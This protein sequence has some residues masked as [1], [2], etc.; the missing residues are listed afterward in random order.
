MHTYVYTNCC[1]HACDSF[2]VAQSPLSLS[3]RFSPS[4][5][6]HAVSE[7][8]EHSTLEGGGLSTRLS[9]AP[10]PGLLEET[11]S[12][13]N[14]PTNQPASQP[15][16]HSSMRAELSSISPRH[17]V[18]ATVA[19]LSLMWFARHHHAESARLQTDRCV[20]S[21]SELSADVASRRARPILES[22][23]DTVGTKIHLEVH[24][25]LALGI[26]NC[27]GNSPSNVVQV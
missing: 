24:T 8:V 9:R 17:A 5:L 3:Q 11:N 20:S 23:W 14:Q 25:R 18:A 15:T 19:V 2:T 21:I 1:G 27:M 4:A 7:T 26:A 10:D 22:G 13:N 16:N 6:G 12:K